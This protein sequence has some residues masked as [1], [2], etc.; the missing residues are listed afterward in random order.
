MPTMA[1]G[2]AATIFIVDTL[3]PLDM[4]IAVLYVGVVLFSAS[5]LERR[6]LLLVGGACICLTLLSFTI[7]HGQD[8]GLAAT[9]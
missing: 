6:G 7:I 5:F 2:L 9:M 3:S 4:A 1:A 8:Y